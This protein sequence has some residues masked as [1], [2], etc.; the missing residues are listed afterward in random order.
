MTGK[1]ESCAIGK[2]DSGEQS[3]KMPLIKNASSHFTQRTLSS[4]TDEYLEGFGSRVTHEPLRTLTAKDLISTP[5][6]DSTLTSNPRHPQPS[7]VTADVP[8]PPSFPYLPTPA[9]AT[10]RGVCHPAR[11]T[12]A[13]LG[14]L[15]VSMM[16]LAFLHLYSPS[17]STSIAGGGVTAAS[18]NAKAAAFAAGGHQLRRVGV[19]GASCEQRAGSRRSGTGS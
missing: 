11:M 13:I 2:R 12:L 1:T 3:P 14:S 4:T 15:C 10:K 5:S 6:F 16:L 17:S 9:V 19:G 7:I 8:P 18:L